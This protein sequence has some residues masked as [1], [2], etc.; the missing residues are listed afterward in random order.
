VQR[1]LPSRAAGS[2]RE[3]DPTRELLEM[4]F[5]WLQGASGFPEG[6]IGAWRDL[7]RRRERRL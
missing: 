4:C 3:G 6:R 2:V 1:S 7:G 5:G